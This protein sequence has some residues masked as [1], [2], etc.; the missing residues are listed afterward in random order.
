MY[1]ATASAI[2]LIQ[3]SGS[4]GNLLLHAGSYRSVA[5]CLAS[6]ACP[7]ISSNHFTSWLKPAEDAAQVAGQAH[8]YLPEGTRLMQVV[9]THFEEFGVTDPGNA[10]R[11][12]RVAH[13]TP[14]HQGLPHNITS[15]I[16]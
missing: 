16:E 11:A 1:D 13:H 14:S 3:G 4:G 8:Q 5:A 6:L 15:W 10:W 12:R 2:T 9:M 7:G